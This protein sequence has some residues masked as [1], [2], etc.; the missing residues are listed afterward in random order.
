M[1]IS[2]GFKFLVLVLMLA[3]YV[4]LALLLFTRALIAL[5]SRR[6]AGRSVKAPARVPTGRRIWLSKGRDKVS[7]KNRPDWA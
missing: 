3:G 5:V 2:E 7:S 4:L 1:S 6:A